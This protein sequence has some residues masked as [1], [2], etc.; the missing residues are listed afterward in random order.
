MSA[1]ER[2]G[3]GVGSGGA[4]AWMVAST[5]STISR[6]PGWSDASTPR[7]KSSGRTLS[8]VPK[9]IAS[10]TVDYGANRAV[11]GG[12]VLRRFL[13]RDDPPG[14]LAREGVAQFAFESLLL[15]LV[16]NLLAF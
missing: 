12:P 7:R 6:G 4:V 1:A 8:S 10:L 9:T 5:R 11:E 13:F 16:E 14:H 2:P 3:G 15:L